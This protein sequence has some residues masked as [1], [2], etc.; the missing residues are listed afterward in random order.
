MLFIHGIGHAHP[1]TKITNA[2]LEDLD[3]GTSDEWIVERTGIHSRHTVLPLDYIL[4]TRNADVRVADEAAICD[5]A[6]LGASAARMAIKRAGIVRDDIGL[7]ISGGSLPS[8]ASPAEGCLIAAALNLDVPAFDIR[9][10]C[11]SF[12]VALH[13]LSMM[14]PDQLPA[15]ILLATPETMTR[16]VDYNDRNA[17][18]LWGDGAAALIVSTT[19]PGRAAVGFTSFDSSPLGCN[20]VTVPYAGHFAQE[21]ATVQTF[22][23][24]RT[25]KVLRSIQDQPGTADSRRLHFIGHQANML[26]LE[27]VCERCGIEPEYH[28]F[29]VSRMGNTAT[30]GAPSV[31]SECWDRFREGDEV[32]IVGVGSGLSWSGA[33][34]R[35][36]DRENDRLR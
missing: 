30:A 17:A 29:N 9:S 24:K 21:G 15:Y 11:T 20:K 23:I 26:M 19:R 10:A 4:E 12:G 2:F 25:C 36:G 33:D 5:N 7:V 1:E 28:H 32:A 14:Q 34:V 3:I 8:Y 27:S 13:W 35:F 31:L 18:V 22:A 6:E 16:S